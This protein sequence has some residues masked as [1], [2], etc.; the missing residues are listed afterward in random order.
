M[1]QDILPE[2]PLFDRAWQLRGF[3]LNKAMHALRFAERRD[4]FRRDAEAYLDG[5]GL[6]AAEKSAV[7]ACDWRELARLGGNVFYVL[8]LAAFHPATMTEIGA[9][10]AGMPHATFLRERLG[11]K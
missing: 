6:S 8:K 10:Q 1:T 11:K 7:H 2:T 4:A 5:Y 3:K 9:H